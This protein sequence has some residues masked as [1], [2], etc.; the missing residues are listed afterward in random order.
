MLERLNEAVRIRKAGTH[1]R[2]I[3]SNVRARA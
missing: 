3:G 2:S 1:G